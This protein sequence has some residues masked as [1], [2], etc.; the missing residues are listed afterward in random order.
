M[1]WVFE[2]QIVGFGELHERTAMLFE[3]EEAHELIFQT[4][5][6]IHKEA[7]VT[8]TILQQTCF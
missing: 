8:K 3:D 5:T 7:L 6:S 4:A 2:G 1:N